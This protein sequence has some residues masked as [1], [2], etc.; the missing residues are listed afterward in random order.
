MRSSY[1]LL[2]LNCFAAAPLPF[3]LRLSYSSYPQPYRVKHAG[4]YY[5]NLIKVE[6]ID[7]TNTNISGLSTY[8]STSFTYYPTNFLKSLTAGDY[9]AFFRWVLDYFPCV[10][11]KSSLYQYWRIEEDVIKDVNN[12]IKILR[13]EYNLNI[14]IRDKPVLLVLNTW[15]YPNKKQRLLLTLLL[16]FTAYIGSRL[17]SLANIASPI[18]LRV[19]TSRR[20]I[21]RL[22]RDIN[23][24]T[25]AKQDQVMGHS[26]NGIFQFYIN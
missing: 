26:Y 19:K 5:K 4:D 21:K 6:Y 12:Y 7:T 16:L 3:Y 8:Y 25:A 22:G 17:Y 1:S 23:V 20:Y 15:V 24:V 18:P 2:L 14:S 9:M 10:R 13:K 11:K